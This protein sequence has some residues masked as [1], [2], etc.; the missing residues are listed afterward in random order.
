MK[1]DHKEWIWNGVTNSY[2]IDFNKQEKNI[3][4][5]PRNWRDEI[6]PKIKLEILKQ[7]LPK[8][9]EKTIETT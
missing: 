8:K 6:P 2:R 5:D 4:E 1:Q 7:Y 9:S 3:K